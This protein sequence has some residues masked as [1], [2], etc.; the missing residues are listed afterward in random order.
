MGG[1]ACQGKGHIGGGHHGI[2]GDVHG[3]HQ[4]VHVE[5]RVKLG[6]SLEGNDLRRDADNAATE[7]RG[8]MTFT[9]PLAE[10]SDSKAR[11]ASSLIR[12][13]ALS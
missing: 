2:L 12:T 1:S 4:V 13:S 6:H 9:G 11:K 8:T 5:E 7:H 10:V 3:P